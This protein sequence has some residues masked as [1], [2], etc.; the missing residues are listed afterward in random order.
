MDQVLP[1]QDWG[2]KST[3]TQLPSGH[4][5]LGKGLRPEKSQIPRDE[6]LCQSED[7]DTPQTKPCAPLYPGSY[8]LFLSQQMESGLL[9][10]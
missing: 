5:K 6:F 8:V 7:S 2:T 9:Y 3:T 1:S 10:L 4:P